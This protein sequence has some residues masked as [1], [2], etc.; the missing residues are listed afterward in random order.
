MM[1][2]PEVET[3]TEHVVEKNPG[4]MINQV[5]YDNKEEV[6][7]ATAETPTAVGRIQVIASSGGT[8]KRSVPHYITVPWTE[9][10]KA[11]SARVVG[12]TLTVDASRNRA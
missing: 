6:K 4:P 11:E 1:C 12:K 8:G 5:G 3:A 2:N 7:Q 9:E 10:D